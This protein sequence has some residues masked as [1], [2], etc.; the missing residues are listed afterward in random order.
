MVLYPALNRFK[1]LIDAAWHGGV[2]PNASQGIGP[3]LLVNGLEDL[4]QASV[5]HLM[6]HSFELTHQRESHG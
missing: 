3:P 6:I 1:A 4:F 2:E 5:I